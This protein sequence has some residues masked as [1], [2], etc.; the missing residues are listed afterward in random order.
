MEEKR[1]RSMIRTL[2]PLA[3]ALLLSPAPGWS[4]A[5]KAF[6]TAP[7]LTR[8]DIAMVR[9]LVRED[10]T[11]KPKGTTLSWSNPDSTNSGTVT[12]LDN[13]TSQG[14]DCRRVQYTVKPGAKQPAT[15]RPATY[16]LINCR[17]ADGSW[18]IDSHAKPDKP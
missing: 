9:K 11:G 17:L 5:A 4:Q 2:G 3:V 15:V 7:K 8:T 16:V 14:R 10:L 12:L 6:R 1:M 18:R 13:F